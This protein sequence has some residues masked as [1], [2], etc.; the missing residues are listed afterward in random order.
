MFT[1]NF[2][3]GSNFEKI[4]IKDASGKTIK[5]LT[6]FQIDQFS[7][8]AFDLTNYANGIY[9]IEIIT[10]IKTYKEKILKY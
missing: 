1:I 6:N 5:S 10:D 8:Y 9:Y 2:D 3:K 4:E 7:N